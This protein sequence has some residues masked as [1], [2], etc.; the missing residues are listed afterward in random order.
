MHII[1]LAAFYALIP[2]LP[3]YSSNDTLVNTIG[4]VIALALIYV[5]IRRRF[6]FGII[7]R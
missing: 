1:L 4:E 7:P 6:L 3:F 5:M 2:F